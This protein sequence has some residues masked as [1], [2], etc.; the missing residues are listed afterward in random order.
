MSR[1]GDYCDGVIVVLRS[2]GPPMTVLRTLQGPDRLTLV[3]WFDQEL[4][5]EGTFP[6]VCLVPVDDDEARPAP[7]APRPSSSPRR[8]PRQRRR[9]RR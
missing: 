1:A 4:L 3:C 8:W 6:A 9:S 2:G 5:R 7:S